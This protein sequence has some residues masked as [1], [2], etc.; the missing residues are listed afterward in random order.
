[1]E[2]SDYGGRYGS[3]RSSKSQRLEICISWSST[4]IIFFICGIFFLHQ[5][6]DQIVV[7]CSK[8][9]ICMLLRKPK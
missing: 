2:G 7:F 3:G 8:V 6:I 1:M 4:G 9:E 5:N